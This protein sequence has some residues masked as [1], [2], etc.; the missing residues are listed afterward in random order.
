MKIYNYV[1]LPGLLP[2]T[3]IYGDS[4]S[5][6]HIIKVVSDHLDVTEKEMFSIHRYRRLVEARQLSMFLIRKHTRRS[7]KEIGL[8][9]GGRDHTTAIHSIQHVKDLCDSDEV[10]RNELLKIENKL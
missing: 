2:G 5:A 1:A 7:F 3:P 4:K 8:L 6:G 10:Y 9:F